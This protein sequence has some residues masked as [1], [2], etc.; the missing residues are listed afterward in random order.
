[1]NFVFRAQRH[2]NWFVISI[3]VN[4]KHMGYMTIPF[5]AWEVLKSMLTHGV[6]WFTEFDDV[7]VKFEDVSIEEEGE[8]E[9]KA[10]RGKTKKSN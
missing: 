6:T 4:D 3:L 1:M 7:H 9:K 2:D 10:S 5:A 8:N